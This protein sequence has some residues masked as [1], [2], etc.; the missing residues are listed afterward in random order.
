MASFAAKREVGVE[1]VEWWECGWNRRVSRRR[2]KKRLVKKRR[3]KKR[4]VKKRRGPRMELR[5]ACAGDRSAGSTLELADR[6]VPGTTVQT[7]THPDVE[8]V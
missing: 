6:F 8:G 3:V 2:V 1:R 4:R 7:A 5:A